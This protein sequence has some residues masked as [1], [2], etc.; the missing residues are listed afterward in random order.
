VAVK[1]LFAM[2]DT[3]TTAGS[4]ILAN[5][6]TNYDSAVVARLEAEG[7]VIIGKTRMSEFA[8]SPGS[9]NA[10]YGATR[11]PRNPEYDTG[12]SSSG[13]GAAVAAG[14]VVAAIGTDTGGSIR[15]PSAQCGIVGLKPTFGRVSLY[16][17]VTLAWSFD[18]AGPMTRTVADAALMLEILAGLDTRDPRTQPSTFS[19]APVLEEISVKGL[20]VGVLNEGLPDC[21]PEAKAAWLAG[22]AALEKQGAELVE[23]NIPEFSDLR[24]VNSALLGIEATTFHHPY[25]ISR[26]RDYGEFMRHRILAAYSYTPRAYT[27]GQQ[28]RALLRQRMNS[29]WQ[30]VDVLSTPTT[31]ET[32]PTLGI[33]GS[34]AYTS[35][36]NL[37]GWPAVTVP[38]GQ[39]AERLPF[40]LQLV[41]KPWDEVTIL[42]A[43]RAVE[44]AGLYTV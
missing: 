39:T 18:H 14:L 24:T 31:P 28:A 11:N 33:P 4:K 10:H 34:L 15:I 1:D 20:R 22:L 35:P 16:G 9:N 13:S 7:A 38:V 12:G 3:I 43:A 23:L 44:A 2:R 32:A 29:I 26:I 40:G 8:Y 42:R 41:G 25:L 30:Q 21:T 36:F 6:L 5:N 37:L 17:A 27:Q 19:A